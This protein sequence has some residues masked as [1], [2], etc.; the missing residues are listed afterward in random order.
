M[1]DDISDEERRRFFR[2][3]DEIC[4]EVSEVTEQEYQNAPDE[5]VKVQQSAF[6]LSATFATMN[7]NHIPMMNSIRTSFPEIAQYLDL[8]NRKIDSLSQHLL[9]EELLCSDK[10]KLKVNI[11]ASGIAFDSNQTYPLNQPLMLRLVLL[12]EKIG[13]EVFGRVVNIQSSA[14]S[15]DITHISVDFEHIRDT[16]QEL[17]IKHNL[18]KQM[19]ELRERSG[20]S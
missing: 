6:A 2:I 9:N 16:D 11:S 7:H 17:L 18:N 13:I 12:P 19:Q 3:E 1:T 14:D 4:L 20:N 8:M 10:N 15:S 5:L